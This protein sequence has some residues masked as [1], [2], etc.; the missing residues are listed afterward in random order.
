MREESPEKSD[1][2]ITLWHSLH[3]RQSNSSVRHRMVKAPC[4]EHSGCEAGLPE[5][6]LVHCAAHRV[7]VPPRQL[8]EIEDRASSTWCRP[9][10]RCVPTEIR[11]ERALCPGRA[12]ARAGVPL[13]GDHHVLPELGKNAGEQGRGEHRKDNP[14]RTLL[15]ARAA[16]FRPV[17]TNAILSDPFPVL[18]VWPPG[19][20]AG[21]SVCPR[22]L[23]ESQQHPCPSKA[24]HTH[25]R[26]A[27][28]TSSG[29]AVRSLPLPLTE[30]VKATDF[31][32]WVSVRLHPQPFPSQAAA[33]QLPTCTERKTG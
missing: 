33:T 16:R 26:C 25:F 11:H 2:G 19:W 29:C 28:R 23:L 15:E 1:G 21:Q 20:Q 31:L 3:V 27:H 5:Q 30:R 13:L 32:S 24:V 12:T 8:P 4:T 9:A 14:G 17:G 10:L 6:G 22:K 18:S 7:P